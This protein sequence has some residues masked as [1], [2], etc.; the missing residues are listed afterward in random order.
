MNTQA[1]IDYALDIDLSDIENEIYCFRSIVNGE[2]KNSS[3]LV[4]TKMFFELNVVTS[5]YSNNGVNFV[6]RWMQE[7]KD[8]VDNI[9][10]L[11]NK[12]IL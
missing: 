9:E 1:Q 4:S 7:N 8:K 3:I 2:A 5:F 6:I 11:C 10:S 12:R